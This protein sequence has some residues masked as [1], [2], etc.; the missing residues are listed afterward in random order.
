MCVSEYYVDVSKLEK[1]A[2][3]WV[4]KGVK[5]REECGSGSVEDKVVASPTQLKRTEKKKSR[6]YWYASTQQQR[7]YQ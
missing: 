3:C 1:N 2:T 7:M 6:E 5:S 4:R